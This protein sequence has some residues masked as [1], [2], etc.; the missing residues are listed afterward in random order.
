MSRA[1]HEFIPINVAILTVSDSRGELEDTSGDYLRTAVEDAGHRVITKQMTKNDRYQIRALVSAWI[2]DSNI[3]AILVNGGTGFDKRNATPEA[4]T[5][6][7][8]KTIEGFG[9]IFRLI[10]FDEIGTSAMQSRAIAG[11]AN[12]TVIFAIPG[13]TKACKT[14][15]E[16]LIQP[17]L[18]ARQGP[19][20]F[21]PHLL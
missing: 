16:K 13:S 14:G 6:L 8:D 5:P 20:N 7:F 3:Q 18:D 12:N 11:I 1:G 17:Q 19:C 4:L 9:E 15:W 2:A 21:I 10:S